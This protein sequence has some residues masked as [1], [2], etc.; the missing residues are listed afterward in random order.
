M[1]EPNKKRNAICCMTRWQR[2]RTR[3]ATCP[4]SPLCARALISWPSFPCILPARRSRLVRRLGRVVR[5]ISWLKNPC[6]LNQGSG[7]PRTQPTASRIQRVAPPPSFPSFASVIRFAFIRVHSRL[8]SPPLRA[9]HPEPRKSYIANRTFSGAAFR[10]SN[11]HSSPIL[12]AKN[13]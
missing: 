4:S 6:L 10:P 3:P 12:P 11:T 5:A 1:T 13:E 9:A 7:T 2:G 8:E